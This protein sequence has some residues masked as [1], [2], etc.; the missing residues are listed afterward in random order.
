VKGSV[1]W[2]GL[3]LRTRLVTGSVIPLG[4]AVL[5]G[6]VAVAGI[7]AAGRTAEVDR[8]T[9][10]E[11]RVLVQLV[12]SGQLP[13]PLPVPAGSS[14][15]AQVLESDRVIAS[16][17]SASRLLPLASPRDVGVRTIEEPAVG[18]VPIRVRVVAAR[19][20][21]RPVTVMVGAPLGDVRRATR[22]LRLVLMVVAP[23]LVLLATLLAWLLVGR[24]LR[25]VE[26]LRLSAVE[27]L[28]AGTGTR[29]LELPVHEDELHRLADTFN[30]VL[31]SLHRSVEQ[32]QAFVANAAHELRSPV[33]SMRVQLDVAARH[34]DLVDAAD[35]VNELSAE[36]DRLGQ[37]ADDLLLLARLDAGRT[38]AAEPVD[39][40]TFADEPATPVIVR[41]D[42]DALRRL[43]RNLTDNARRHADRVRT[44]V[45]TEG[46][47]AVLDVDDDGPGI[48]LADRR[49]VLDRWVRLD[50]A[51]G[52]S[53]GGAGLGLALVT[54]IALAH[55]GHVEVLD[56]PLGG[57]RLRVRLPLTQ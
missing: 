5:V 53:E 21:G 36:V 32:Q 19:S 27:L 26:R 55:G 40:A 51:R 10:A 15:L 22:A 45:F 37:L 49:R 43:H 1:W 54:E 12:S 16:S 47:V 41:G 4:V 42:E 31:S 35:L 33:A 6:T 30:D 3:S 8:Q 56:S 11:S 34:P 14:L 28:R 52:R 57:A 17:A 7:F 29:L 23:L 25:P 39:L 46:D 50:T 20:A 48:P 2:R 13:A 38:V 18:R 44:T 24:S 9:A